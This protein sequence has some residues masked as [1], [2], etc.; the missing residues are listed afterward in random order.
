M[1]YCFNSA[2]ADA[3]ADELD[4]EE[5]LDEIKAA[6]VLDTEKQ[7]REDIESSLSSGDIHG[8]VPDWTTTMK[9]LPIK[10]VEIETTALDVLYEMAGYEVGNPEVKVHMAALLAS[11]AAAS[12][13]QSLGH[14]WAKR[15]AANVAEARNW[16]LS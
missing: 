4:R 11:D 13:R 6:A 3:Y 9:G 16:G 8:I 15:N 10:V 7:I 2:A 1:S 14:A 5:R 12:L